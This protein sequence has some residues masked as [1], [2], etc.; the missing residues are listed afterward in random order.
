MKAFVETGKLPPPNTVCETDGKVF[1]TLEVE[2][3]AAASALK[4]GIAK[5]WL[6][7]SI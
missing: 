4:R 6:E 2:G 7:P 3:D 1:E 5:R